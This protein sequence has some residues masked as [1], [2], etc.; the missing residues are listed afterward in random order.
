MIRR[1]ALPA[2][3]AGLSLTL[4]VQVSAQNW[5]ALGQPA[6]DVAISNQAEQVWAIDPDGRVMFSSP[7]GWLEYPGKR[8]AI[9]IAATPRGVPY[10]IDS[11][12]R[13]LRGKGDG[14]TELPGG[15]L[16]KD[17]AVDSAGTAWVVGMDDGIY[18]HDGSGGWRSYPGGIRALAISA[19]RPGVPVIVGLN[20]RIY[21]GG[22]NGWD[23]I[24]GNGLAYD[25]AVGGDGTVFV[26]G[27]DHGIYFSDL[28]Q[29][30]GWI[31]FTDGS[32]GKRI[33][34][35]AVV[36]SLAVVG[37]DDRVWRTMP[38]EQ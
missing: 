7:A 32:L 19:W 15:G 22:P 36:G 25:L 23:E 26:I 5:R 37:S 21:L 12:K 28:R 11:A 6:L 8:A 38:G 35:D 17:I 14:W 33:A 27:M 13:I 3:L 30:S 34:V 29:P 9:A 16:G 24:P 1:C 10:I 31:G 20:R 4:A 2:L 18:W